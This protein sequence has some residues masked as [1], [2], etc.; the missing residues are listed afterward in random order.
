MV[1]TQKNSDERP[2]VR[3][4]CRWLVAQGYTDAQIE[5]EYAV[6]TKRG[7]TNRS[8]RV[9]IAVFKGTRHVDEELLFIVECKRD[10][11]EYAGLDQ[12]RTH[13][14]SV[15]ARVGLWFNGRD[16]SYLVHAENLFQPEGVT[17]HLPLGEFIRQQ[18]EMIAVS[19]SEFSLRKMAGRLGVE[20]SYLSRIERGATATPSDKLMALISK[21]LN[22]SEQ[23]LYALGGRIP[24][25]FAKLI[26]TMPETMV[27]LLQFMEN[28]PK[29]ALQRLVQ[30]LRDDAVRDGDW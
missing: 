29:E 18:R 22:V 13:M 21:E 26:Q 19:D 24:P 25:S 8:R 2:I 5:L 12:L 23:Y 27:P 28:A 16:F 30:K 17:D 20:S 6:P 3:Q 15:G 9:D 11:E 4:M 10:T 7:S 14:R 1:R